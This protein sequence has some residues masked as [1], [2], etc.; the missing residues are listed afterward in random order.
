[1]LKFEIVQ[2]LKQFLF[3]KQSAYRTVF[4]KESSAVEYVLRDLARFCRAHTTSFHPDPHVRCQLEGRREVWLMIQH[5][6]NLSSDDL[7]RLYGRKDLE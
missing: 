3:S 6:I 7:W 4:D 5:Y 2:K 1:M